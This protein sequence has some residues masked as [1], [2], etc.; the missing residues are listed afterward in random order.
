MF[1]TQTSLNG[2]WGDKQQFAAFQIGHLNIVGV[3]DIFSHTITE[4]WTSTSADY[5][6]NDVMVGFRRVNVPEPS[7]LL[8][9]GLG[10]A[11]ARREGAPPLPRLNRRVA[12]MPPEGVLPLR[13][14]DPGRPQLRV[15][16][17]AVLRALRPHRHVRHPHR[18]QARP[19]GPSSRAISCASSSQV[20]WP[21][22]TQ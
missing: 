6:F 17:R 22:F 1:F 21:L 2:V 12:Q 3:E 19:T 13:H 8:L 15:R 9:M 11:A 5:D 10:L 20:V 14:R 7:S 16:Q 18:A 4:V